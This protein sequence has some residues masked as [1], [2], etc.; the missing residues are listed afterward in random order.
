M[1]SGDGEKSLLCDPGSEL[2]VGGRGKAQDIKW[3]EN[4]NKKLVRMIHSYIHVHVTD[5]NID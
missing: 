5:T 1:R 3:D 4:K 2:R